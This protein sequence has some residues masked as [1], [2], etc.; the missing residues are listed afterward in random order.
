MDK[1]LHKKYVPTCIR[2]AGLPDQ[3]MWPQ[4]DTTKYM[5]HNGISHPIYDCQGWINYSLPLEL[6]PPVGKVHPQISMVRRP[7]LQYRPSEY[8]L[9]NPEEDPRLYSMYRYRRGCDDSD[10]VE[11]FYHGAECPSQSGF[12]LASQ[13]TVPGKLPDPNGYATGRSACNS[14]GMY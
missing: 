6:Y 3:Y 11:G 2:H 10:R 13:K 14:C 1:H 9:P 8:V 4:K 7:H 5:C 12:T